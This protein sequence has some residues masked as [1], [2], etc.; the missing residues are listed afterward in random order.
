MEIP[1]PKPNPKC[2]A[3]QLL[4]SNA[5]SKNKG[6]TTYISCVHFHLAAFVA[7][8]FLYCCYPRCCCSNRLAIKPSWEMFDC[9]VVLLIYDQD[10]NY[11]EFYSNLYNGES[12]GMIRATWHCFVFC[13][14]FRNQ[15]FDWI[16]FL[17]KIWKFFF[18]LSFENDHWFVAKIR[19]WF[20]CAF[21]EEFFPEWNRWKNYFSSFFEFFRKKCKIMQNNCM[22]RNTTESI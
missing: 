13:A 6:E 22:H 11:I 16:F 21:V 20:N 12:N 5:K 4:R 15:I 3:Q 9:V 14:N 7:N 18:T 8:P 19:K 1:K 17:R 2:P 10:N